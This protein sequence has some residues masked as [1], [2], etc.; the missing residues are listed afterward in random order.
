MI[1]ITDE[2]IDKSKISTYIRQTCCRK[3][4]RI[5]EIAVQL[6]CCLFCRQITKE[7]WQLLAEM[8]TTTTNEWAAQISILEI[9]DF[10]VWP[11]KL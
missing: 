4:N 10:K 8:T 2:D 6:C 7:M 3:R 11:R 1:T 5:D 9:K